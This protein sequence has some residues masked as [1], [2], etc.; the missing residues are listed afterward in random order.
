MQERR[1]SDQESTQQSKSPFSRRVFLGAGAAVAAG[2]ALGTAGPA[3]ADTAGRGKPVALAPFGPVLVTDPSVNGSYARA[4]R[5]TS[6]AAGKSQTMLATYQA[7]GPSGFPLFRT[8]D[9]GRTWRSYSTIPVSGFALQPTFYELPQ[10]FAGLPKG[11]LLFACNNFGH[12][13]ST[14]I[15]L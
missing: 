14:A 9:D 15:Q 10:A 7:F 12:F 8:D 3:F 6:G 2:A 5:L 1:V 4:V 13:D 11:A